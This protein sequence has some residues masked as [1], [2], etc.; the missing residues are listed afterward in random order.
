MNVRVLAVLLMLTGGTA[1]AQPGSCTPASRW[2]PL[3][4]PRPA[5][6]RVSGIRQAEAIRRRPICSG[7]RVLSRVGGYSTPA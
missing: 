7:S 6:R 1:A 5:L 2:T 4:C 3:L